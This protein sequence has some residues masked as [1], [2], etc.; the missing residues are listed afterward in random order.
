[1]YVNMWCLGVCMWR[2]EANV[3]C[4]PLLLSTLVETGSLSELG[5]HQLAKQADQSAPGFHLS[6]PL[7]PRAGITHATVPGFYVSPGDQNSG[8]LVCNSIHITN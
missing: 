3:K 7:S 4:L 5:A 6:L 8:P 1:M 2:P